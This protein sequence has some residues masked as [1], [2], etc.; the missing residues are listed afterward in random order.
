MTALR[1]TFYV[2][3][4]FMLVCPSVFFACGWDGTAL[5]YT[6]GARPQDLK[7]FAKGKLGVI[8]PGFWHIYL[9]GAYRYL[10]G[11]PLNVVEQ[12]AVQALWTYGIPPSGDIDAS[13]KR[14]L[15]V[16]KTIPNVP[17]AKE[18]QVGRWLPEYA[19]IINC[20]APALRTAMDTLEQRVGRFGRESSQVRSWLQAQDAVFSN[21]SSDKGTMPES[22]ESGMDPLIRADRAYQIAAAKFYRLQYDDAAADFS[23]IAQDKDSP[24]RETARFVAIRCLIRKAT[25]IGVPSPKGQYPPT[26]ADVPLLAQ[27][28]EQLLALLADRHATKYHDA[29]RQLLGFVDYRVRPDERSAELAAILRTARS[30]PAD[31]EQGLSDYV[32]LIEH[33]HIAA[34]DDMGQWIMAWDA[35]RADGQTPP[36]IARLADAAERY[37]R[38]RSPLWLVL[39]LSAARST[40]QALDPLLHDALAVSPD[41]PAYVTLRYHVARIALAR[42]QR[43]EARAL[44]DAV[45]QRHDLDP[46]TWNDLD[47][48]RMASAADFDDFIAHAEHRY[49][50]ESNPGGL[51]EDI[52]ATPDRCSKNLDPI[53]EAILD[54]LP[55]SY[56]LRAAHD[57]RLTDASRKSLA[58]AAWQRAYLL[59]A[60]QPAEDAA[61]L[62]QTLAPEMKNQLAPYLAAAP[63]DRRFAATFALLRSGAPSWCGGVAAI[64]STSSRSMMPLES[65]PVDLKDGAFTGPPAV[66]AFLPA[67]D[68]ETARK[69]LQSLSAVASFSTHVGREALT[70]ARSHPEDPRVP[71]ALHRVVTAS[72]YRCGDD[73]TGTVSRAAFN[74]LHRKYPKSEWTNRTKYWFDGR[75]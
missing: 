57:Q 31:M 53:A 30:Q 36:G 66:P 7:G 45:L 10:S 46:S 60:D 22:A 3:A 73:Q 47:L 51:P 41:S 15:E 29:A 21:C 68:A 35:L 23:A 52:C 63:A 75:P 59:H 28:R 14:W 65:T 40:D 70:F 74:L 62:L 6:F 54:R 33:G 56:Q 19:Q 12:Q 67:A 9:F 44:A 69:Q 37:Q 8:R 64:F 58:M 11:T 4:L 50:S 1:R 43:K 18:I 17:E 49:T 2:L 39:L 5:E 71:E 61:R 16:H 42:G 48:L 24:W 26:T 55:L 27:A 32:A 20:P 25:V 13:V 72:R 34:G 38:T